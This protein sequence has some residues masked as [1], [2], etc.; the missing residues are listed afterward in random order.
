MISVDTNVIVRYLV[1]DVA[2]QALAARTFLEGLTPEHPAFICREVAIELVWVL[3]RAYGFSR[4]QISD[5]LVE[6]IA[7]DSIVV[8]AA[9]DVAGAASRYRRGGVGFAD[10]MVL[11]A[12]ERAGATPLHTFDRRLAGVDGAILVNSPA[13]GAAS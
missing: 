13:A 7:T 10:L 9:D 12:A 4:A 11:A 5:V 1:N 2:E 8:E 3:E 6:L